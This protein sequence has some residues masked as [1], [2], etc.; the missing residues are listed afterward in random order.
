M[1]RTAGS[2][3][4]S[5]K[6]FTCSSAV[7]PLGAILWRIR[8]EVPFKSLSYR[9]TTSASLLKTQNIQLK[10]VIKSIENAHKIILYVP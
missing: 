6:H 9:E 2:V 10:H 4:R 7:K 5:I 1:P 3:A 8:S